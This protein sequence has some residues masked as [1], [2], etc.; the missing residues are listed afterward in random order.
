MSR[1]KRN[2]NVRI[3]TEILWQAKSIAYGQ[4][5]TL[6]EWITKVIAHAILKESPNATQSTD[7]V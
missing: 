3:P 1:E 6:Q 2:L 5:L 7:R 4:G